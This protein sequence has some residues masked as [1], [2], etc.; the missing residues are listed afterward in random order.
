[1][2][3]REQPVQFIEVYSNLRAI[4]P[5]AITVLDQGVSDGLPR[6]GD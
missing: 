5:V 2:A 6:L 1:M 4:E 3:R